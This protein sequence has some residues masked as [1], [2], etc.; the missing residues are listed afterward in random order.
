[1][2]VAKFSRS[3]DGYTSM[4]LKSQDV[5]DIVKS[6][7]NGNTVAI[8]L[9]GWSYRPE[10]QEAWRGS[11]KVFR[12]DTDT[13]STLGFATTTTLPLSISSGHLISCFPSWIILAAEKLPEGVYFRTKK[14][15]APESLRAAAR[16]LDKGV[17]SLLEMT[18]TIDISVNI[19]GKSPVAPSPSQEVIGAV[20]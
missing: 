16:G 20:R 3:K 8:D 12:T 19:F 10:G 9:D 6:M 15:F 4:Y 7:G 18:R 14:P 11:M 1:M 17:N 13:L 2:L 5:S